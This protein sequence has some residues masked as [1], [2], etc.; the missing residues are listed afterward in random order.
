MRSHFPFVCRPQEQLSREAERARR[1][2]A[3]CE[4]ARRRADELGQQLHSRQ[5]EDAA[6]D[7][8]VASLAKGLEAM[9]RDLAKLQR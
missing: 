2:A 5:L 7:S 3:D 4:E 1:A 9:Q 8:A 6:R